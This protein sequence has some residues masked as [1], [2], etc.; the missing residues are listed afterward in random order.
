VAKIFIVV[1]LIVIVASLGSALA[2]LFRKD[3]EKSR[4]AKALTV[5]VSLS[6]GLFL[7]LLGGLY[8][9]WIPAHGLR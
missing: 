7:V 2:L 8:F 5:R 3:G 9:G 1:V 6:I 4:M